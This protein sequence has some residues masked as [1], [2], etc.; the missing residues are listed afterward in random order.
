[1]RARGGHDARIGGVD[2]V[3]VRADLAVLGVERRRHRHGGRIAAAA[4]ERRHFLACTKR[5]GS[6]R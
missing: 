5:P 2:A 3:D 4:S 1:M 6:R